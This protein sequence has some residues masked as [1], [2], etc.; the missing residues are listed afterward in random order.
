MRGARAGTDRV[1][2]GVDGGGTKT[3]LCLL[4]GGGRVVAEAETV[5][6]YSTED[7][8]GVV[9]RVLDDAVEALCAPSGIAEGGVE[10]A[11]V[12]LPGYGE[13]SWA[14]PGLDAAARRALGR[15]A[16]ERVTCGNDM[17][18]AWA[19]SLGLADGVNVIAGTGSMAYGERGAA[20]AR[21][22]GWGELFGDEG[23]AHWVGV[24][25][26]SLFSR[27]SDGRAP[28]GPLHD[29][30][31]Q[32]LGIT[33]DLDAVDVV[34]NRWAGDRARVA[35]L[36][37]VVAAAAQDGD[38]GAAEVLDDAAD[39]L[40]A[41]VDA[42]R[43]PLGFDGEEVL[44]VSRSGGVFRAAAVRDAFDA[45][46]AALGRVELRRPLHPPVLGAAL[47]AARLAGSPLDEG[48]RARLA[49]RPGGRVR[50]GDGAPAGAQGEV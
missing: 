6:T 28:V 15:W 9:S 30:L 45:R 22:G 23:S 37:R 17:V 12:G 32:H 46:V 39:H 10:H 49:G 4:D 16:G 47:Q 20:R 18:C 50:G 5:G 11:F 8:V 14:V 25:G 3:A 27:M 33:Q 41:L 43:R 44:R 40:V 26:L 31:R 48:A 2:L 29:H 34:L 19:G 7:P 21:A 38:A 13:M 35:G 24:R 36:S 1:Y 42:V